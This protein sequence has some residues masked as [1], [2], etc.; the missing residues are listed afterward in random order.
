MIAAQGGDPDADLP[1][2]RETHELTATRDGV[3]TSLDALAVG[4]AAWRLGA[5]RSRKEDRVQP[6]AGV[7]IH[8]KPGDAVRAG[9]PVLTLHTDTP[10]RFE[11]AIE[12]LDGAW[13]VR[14]GEEPKDHARQVILDRV[15]AQ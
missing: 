10:E 9:Q 1:A 2:A 7:T 13:E 5:G 12:A 11:R 8:A 14:E 15:G 3:M 6:A 4:I